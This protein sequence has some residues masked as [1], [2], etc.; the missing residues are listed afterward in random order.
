MAWVRACVRVPGRGRGPGRR[1]NGSLHFMHMLCSPS[2]H[3]SPWGRPW[4]AGQVATPTRYRFWRIYK[5]VTGRPT[6]LL[7]KSHP[8]SDACM[9]IC[10]ALRTDT[11]IGILVV[12][13]IYI[14]SPLLLFFEYKICLK[15]NTIMFDQFID[16]NTNI[17]NAKSIS[18]DTSRN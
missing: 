6:D 12:L 8:P 4:P 2:I 18:L 7:L 11:C 3:H 5:Y 17:H 13:L 10:C 14:L 1:W 15:S 16:K 9:H